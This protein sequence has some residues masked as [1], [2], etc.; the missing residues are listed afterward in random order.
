MLSDRLDLVVGSELQHSLVDEAGSDDGTLDGETLGEETHVG[1]LEVTLVD[2]KREDG[3]ARGHDGEVDTP[4]DL[5]G[6]GD[7]KTVDGLDILELLDTLG[8]V[9][10]AGTESLSLLLLGV[11][12]REDDNVAT[13]L[14]SEL[15]GQVTETTNTDDTDALSGL[16][17]V[18]VEGLENGGTTALKRG[19]SLVGEVVGDLE[20]ESLTPDTVRGERTLVGI[21]VTVHL[22]LGTVGLGTLQALLAVGARV[23]LVT[24]T[25]AVTLDKS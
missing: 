2:G 17:V 1:N 7:E 22:S 10:L 24:P 25:N 11:S 6:G 3:T 5:G 13:H 20:E 16:G 9:E 23:V 8:G 4:V 21:G 14:G 12:T 18:E 19:S 15:D